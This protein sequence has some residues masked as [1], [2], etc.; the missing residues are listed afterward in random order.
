MMKKNRPGIEMTLITEEADA[1]R[2]AAELMAQTTT[3]GVRIAHEERLE[4]ERRRERVETPFGPADVKVAVL[5][6]GTERMSPEYDW[7]RRV[8]EETGTPILEVYDA[9][10]RAWADR[11]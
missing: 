9:V 7:C 8:A 1:Q 11:S 6:G 3:L 2:I 4:L 5:P 10:R